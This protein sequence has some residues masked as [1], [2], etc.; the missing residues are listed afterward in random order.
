MRRGGGVLL[1]IIGLLQMAGDILRL[2]ALKAF[3]LASAASP[4]PKV[5]SAVQGLE[6]YSTRFYIDWTDTNRQAHST[7]ITPELNSH[8]RGPYNRRNVYGA[9]LAYG[10]VLVSNSQSRPMFESVARYAL[11]GSAPLLR[12]L[13]ID[14]AKVSGVHIRLVPRPGAQLRGLPLIFEPRCQ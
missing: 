13:G 11:C 1:L 8:I 9:V 2:P 3:G 14:P 5:F 12:E 6:T 10:P 7:E 4:A